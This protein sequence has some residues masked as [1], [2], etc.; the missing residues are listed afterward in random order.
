M[1]TDP[2]YQQYNKQRIVDSGKI[3]GEVYFYNDKAEDRHAAIDYT[4]NR[5][6]RESHV[7]RQM[8]QR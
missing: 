1:R 6:K 8:D 2:L 3:I 4:R 5:A 7:Q